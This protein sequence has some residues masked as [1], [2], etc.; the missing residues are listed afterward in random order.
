MNVNLLSVFATGLFSGGITCLAVQGGL[1]TA[2]VAKE[3]TTNVVKN[4][5]S[6]TAFFIGKLSSHFIFGFLLGWAGSFFQLSFQAQIL[7]Q[8]VAIVVMVSTAL[9]MITNYPLFRYF[10]IPSSSFLLRKIHG[11]NVNHGV[12]MPAFVGFAT[13]LIPCGATQAMMA[14]SV[15]SGNPLTGA[16]IMS[17][18]VVGTIPVFSLLGIATVRLKHIFHVQFALVAAIIILFL[19]FFNLNNVLALSANGTTFGTLAR[20]AYCIF[21]ICEETFVGPPVTKET[22]IMTNTGYA[23]REFVVR[24][25]S[26][27]TLDLINQSAT[28]CTQS[29]TIPSLDVHEIVPVG[30]DKLL[31]FIAPK[32]K[33]IVSFMCSMGMYVGRIHVI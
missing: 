16:L 10:S 25:G 13:V 2:M 11:K 20:D 14:L 15:A 7:L 8:T 21:S 32:E 4:A 17:V 1:F 26:G 28:G 23:P 30:Q 33:G 5:L 19:A 27:V 6:F 29:F 12:Y 3:Q 9:S 31:T 24:A 18:F 22:I